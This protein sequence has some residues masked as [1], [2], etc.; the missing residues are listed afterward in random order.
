MCRDLGQQ[1]MRYVAGALFGVVLVVAG[2]AASEVITTVRD[3]NP[4]YWGTKID[5]TAINSAAYT[6]WI[7]A[8]NVNAVA[9]DIDYTNSAGTAVTMTCQTSDVSTTANGSGRDLH[10]L[11]ISSGTATSTPITWSNAVAGN[12]NWTWTVDNVPA[13]LLN[14]A[15]TATGGDGND[16]VTV[17]ARGIS[18]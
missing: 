5:D 15:F 16:K 11:S 10:V 1:L 7:R 18:P 2:V 14:C 4:A 13:P 6:G 8:A 9:F 17:L 3:D 12:E